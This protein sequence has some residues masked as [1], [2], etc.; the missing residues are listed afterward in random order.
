M[1]RA[2]N[3]Y[4]LVLWWRVFCGAVVEDIKGKDLEG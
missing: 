1:S 2:L 4:E 3:T